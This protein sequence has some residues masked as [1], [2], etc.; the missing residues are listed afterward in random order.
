VGEKHKNAPKGSKHWRDSD[1]II[2]N[3]KYEEGK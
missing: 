1:M 3:N 2:S